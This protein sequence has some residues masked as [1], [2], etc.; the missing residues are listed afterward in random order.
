MCTYLLLADLCEV[1]VYG[2]INCKFGWKI[3]KRLKQLRI[4]VKDQHMARL[5]TDLNEKWIKN[6]I[7]CGYL[8][9]IYI[10][11]CWLQIY[12]KNSWV[13]KSVAIVDK[14]QNMG[15]VTKDTN[16]S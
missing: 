16:R 12:L 4:Y 8:A 1:L 3:Y 7:N 9:K 6:K 10:L 11:I 2:Y 13:K 14:D 15:E 5:I